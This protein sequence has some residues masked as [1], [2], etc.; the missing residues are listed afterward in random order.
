MTPNM[1]MFGREIQLPVDLICSDVLP[2][3]KKEAHAYVLDLERRIEM[4]HEKAK[5]HL[6]KA[7]CY[8]RSH[9][10]HKVTEGRYEVGGAV[11][12]KVNTRQVGLSPKLQPKYD[13]PYLITKTLSDVV[14]RIQKGPRHKPKVVHTNLLKLWRGRSVLAPDGCSGFCRGHH[15][16]T[17]TGPYR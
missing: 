16:T 1:L 15:R 14:V 13:G 17:P 8:Q 2:G 4:A 12:M 3:E 11:M 9:Y 6:K 10:D 7:A 5:R